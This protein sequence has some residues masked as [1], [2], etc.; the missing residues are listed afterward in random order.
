MGDAQSL[1]TT[2]TLSKAEG[3]SATIL[4]QVDSSENRATSPQ[5]RKSEA[6]VAE[7]GKRHSSKA[8]ENRRRHS[9]PEVSSVTQNSNE[10]ALNNFKIYFH[11]RPLRVKNAFENHPVS[12]KKVVKDKE[13]ATFLED[14]LEYNGNA[15][16]ILDEIKSTTEGKVTW[17]LVKDMLERPPWGQR[18]ASK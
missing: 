1:P 7:P 12:G 10:S 14:A 11:R 4:A 9:K 17:A 5:K 18:S 6:G 2:C 8:G 16:E 15:A 13:F 3:G